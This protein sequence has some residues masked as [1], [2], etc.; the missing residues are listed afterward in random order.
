MGTV[1]T[2]LLLNTSTLSLKGCRVAVAVALGL[3]TR[4]KPLVATS[5]RM[6][7]FCSVVA[8]LPPTVKLSPMSTCGVPAHWVTLPSA[9]KDTFSSPTTWLYSQACTRQTFWPSLLVSWVG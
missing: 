7:V 3:V 8:A 6:A 9:S 5:A 4:R 1:A 2:R